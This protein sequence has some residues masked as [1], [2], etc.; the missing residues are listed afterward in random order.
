MTSTRTLLILL[1]LLFVLMAAVYLFPIGGSYN[2]Y[3]KNI[4]FLF[5]PFIAAFAGYKAAS[6]YGFK[7]AHGESLL[8][9][10]LGL[11][12]FAIG[13]TIFAIFDLV[14]HID[15]FPSIADI[16]YLIAYPLILVGVL[17]EIGSYKVSIK[18]LPS[19]FVSCI[20]IAVGILVFNI[21]IVPSY[22]NGASFLANIISVSY[23]ICD[24][25]LMVGITYVLLM[26][27]DFKGGKLYGAW[28]AFI[29]ATIFMLLGD[30]S[31]AIYSKPYEENI[32]LYKDIDLFWTLSYL[33][34]AYGLFQMNNIIRNVQGKIKGWLLAVPEADKKISA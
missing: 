10:A 9:I 3:I 31:F 11:L 24:V 17:R 33:F 34:F 18:P 26:T 29:I 30:I 4:L 8:L 25:V 22:S 23:G 27:M 1:P 20:A 19:L 6:A 21:S 12:C 16:F 14:L 2:I 5:P 7:N 32:T 13:E 28:F 15:P